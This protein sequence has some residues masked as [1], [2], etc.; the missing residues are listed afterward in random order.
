MSTPQ[1]EKRV[2]YISNISKFADENTLLSRFS[3]YGKIN[4]LNL[5]DRDRTMMAFVEYDTADAASFALYHLNNAE[6]QG[7]NIKVNYARDRTQDKE[8]KKMNNNQQPKKVTPLKKRILKIKLLL[9]LI[10]PTFLL[11]LL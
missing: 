7:T 5:V 1:S 11:V 9:S 2:L 8:K 10:N 6:I 3:Q 4:N